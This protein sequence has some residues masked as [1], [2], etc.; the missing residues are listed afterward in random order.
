MLL[1]SWKITCAALELRISVGVRTEGTGRRIDGG[2]EEYEAIGAFTTEGPMLVGGLCL[3]GNCIRCAKPTW[4]VSQVVHWGRKHCNNSCLGWCGAN[5][6]TILG[7][8]FLVFFYHYLHV[9]GQPLLY[10]GS[11]V[12]H[13]VWVSLT[14]TTMVLFWA[15]L[16][17]VRDYFVHLHSLYTLFIIMGAPLM[18]FCNGPTPWNVAKGI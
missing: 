10:G 5:F 14:G 16:S 6:L 3:G 1:W 7:F 12:V 11:D 4:M 15:H 8:N 17:V 13:C 2:S 9:W 18:L